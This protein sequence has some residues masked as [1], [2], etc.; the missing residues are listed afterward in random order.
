VNF[1]TREF[2]IVRISVESDAAGQIAERILRVE[3]TPP[4]YGPIDLVLYLWPFLAL[5]ALWVKAIFKHRA[6]AREA[7]S[8]EP[9]PSPHPVS[10]RHA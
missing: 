9:V 8:T 7:P 2:W 3:V 6:A 4:G 5:G 10:N 1:P